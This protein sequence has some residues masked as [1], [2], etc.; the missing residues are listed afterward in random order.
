MVTIILLMIN[1]FLFSFRKY[2]ALLPQL[3]LLPTLWLTGRFEPCDQ[4]HGILYLRTD[5]HPYGLHQIQGELK[6]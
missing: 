5:I 2:G 4:Q 6:A 1:F 3:R